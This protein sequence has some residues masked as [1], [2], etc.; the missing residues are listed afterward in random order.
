M[1]MLSLHRFS[2]DPMQGRV[3]GKPCPEVT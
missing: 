3:R 2:L 1:L